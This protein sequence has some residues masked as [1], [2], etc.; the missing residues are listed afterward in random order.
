MKL[1]IKKLLFIFIF[2][3]V[4]IVL[5]SCGTRTYSL[6][7]PAEV[8]ANISNLETIEVGTEVKLT[9]NVPANKEVESFKVNNVEVS[10]DNLTYTFSIRQNTVVTVTFKDIVIEEVRYRLTLPDGVTANVS[11]LDSIL[12]NTEITLTVSVPEGKF[13][14]QLKINN[15]VVSVSNN[16]YTFNITRNTV[17]SV[18]FGDVDPEV[19]TY[20]LTLPANVTAN[21]AN[22]DRIVENTEVTLTVTPP[23]GKQILD[24]LLD[25]VSVYD[26][27]VG[28]Q[29]TFNIS[30]NTVVTVTFE[31]I[32]EEEKYSLTLPSEVIANVSNLEN[33]LKNTEITLTVSVPAG[34]FLDQLKVNNAVV[35]VSNNKYTFNITQNTVVTVIFGDIDPGETTY[36][37]TLP[38]GVTAN[39]ANLDRIVEN[40]EVTL[41]VTPPAG[42]EIDELFLD[43]VPV[44]VI[45]NQYTFNINQNIVVTVTFKDIPGEE[46]WTKIGT[47]ALAS[48]VESLEFNLLRQGTFNLEYSM[49]SPEVLTLQVKIDNNLNFSEGIVFL[50]IGN[51]EVEMFIQSPYIYIKTTSYE[52]GVVTETVKE[53]MYSDL[54]AQALEMFGF[55][56]V[57]SFLPE[58]DRILDGG[59]YRTNNRF[60]AN[61]KAMLLEMTTRDYIPFEIYQLDGKTKVIMTLTGP[62]DS[63]L[64]IPV[65]NDPLIVEIILNNGLLEKISYNLHVLNI[66][67]EY[68]N[69][70]I[71]L[72]SDLNT[73]PK[74]FDVS[75]I[76]LHFGSEVVTVEVDQDYISELEVVDSFDPLLIDFAFSIISPYIENKTIEGVY[77]DQAFTTKAKVENLLVDEVHLYYKVAE[78][79]Q[80]NT[81]IDDFFSGDYFSL[82]SFD[83][84]SG[85]FEGNEG[86]VYLYDEEFHYF[87]KQTGELY[88]IDMDEPITAV[89]LPGVYEVESLKEAFE[90]F[91]DDPY[92]FVNNNYY[93][94]DKGIVIMNEKGV[95]IKSDIYGLE[96][97]LYIKEPETLD[98]VDMYLAVI[99]A[100]TNAIVETVEDY[101][102]FADPYF[103]DIQTMEDDIEFL[104][105]FSSGAMETL[106]LKQMKQIGA[107]DYILPSS[108][109]GYT[110]TLIEDG[111]S[112]VYNEFGLFDSTLGK[113]VV[114]EGTKTFYYLF[115]LEELPEPVLDNPY[116]EVVGYKIGDDVI[117]SVEDL[118][119]YVTDSK[120]L[121]L[122][123][124][125]DLKSFST[126]LADVK[127]EG[128][129]R[130]S[131][132]AHPLYLDLDEFYFVFY[133]DGWLDETVIKLDGS[134]VEIYSEINYFKADLDGLAL[135]KLNSFTFNY[136]FNF[137]LFNHHFAY[138]QIIKDVFSG[139]LTYEMVE[140]EYHFENG[141]VVRFEYGQMYI[142]PTSESMSFGLTTT[143]FEFTDQLVT[144]YENSVIIQ[145]DVFDDIILKTYDE[146]FV[147][148]P[149][150]H[151]GVEGYLFDNYYLVTEGIK[152]DHVF[153][154]YDDYIYNGGHIVL[155]AEYIELLPPTTYLEKFLI[156][157]QYVLTS[158]SHE[159]KVYKDVVTLIYRHD[160]L[161]AY[162]DNF[163]EVAY[164]F[165]DDDIIRL[166][167]FY[168]IINIDKL[169]QSVDDEDF[170]L[171]SDDR[172]SLT[173][174]YPNIYWFEMYLD[175]SYTYIDGID[176]DEDVYFTFAIE[177]FT[178]PSI[179][180]SEAIDE[181][182]E[183]VE[184]AS[185]FTAI[186]LNHMDIEE[187]VWVRVYFDTGKQLNYGLSDFVDFFGATLEVDD[188]D[189]TL[190]YMANGEEVTHR[191][192]DHGIFVFDTSKDSVVILDLVNEAHYLHDMVSLPEG[193]VGFS[194]IINWHEYGMVVT[195]LELQQNYDTGSE[196]YLSAYTNYVDWTTAS[197][198][199]DLHKYIEVEYTSVYYGHSIT[200]LFDLEDDVAIVK[201]HGKA[202]LWIVEFNDESITITTDDYILTTTIA[203]R[204]DDIDAEDEKLPL[205]DF[206]NVIDSMID[207]KNILS[208]EYA[209][210]DEDGVYV[211]FE[212]S[213]S[214]TIS[215]IELYIFSGSTLYYSYLSLYQQKP[216]RP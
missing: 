168:S 210:L 77:L 5:A 34:K 18:V 105:L 13:L 61:L 39:V 124:E 127:D 76:H 151:I 172:Y 68:S 206:A 141:A 122:S 180:F 32:P 40:A 24:L 51:S 89:K 109:N 8:T 202:Q 212:N 23:A 198:I 209:V 176:I 85:Y 111:I 44:Y 156:N 131:Y 46:L 98:F 143:T 52:D 170:I 37:L 31:N 155:F 147:A 59:P 10:L 142:T 187:A 139:T 80:L 27:I 7:L 165:V 54:T 106:T 184:V 103:Q 196:I 58:G 211:D 194:E 86:I 35:S 149:Y 42:K 197:E 123:Y 195:L 174:S 49:G 204:Y 148:D 22:L 186:D 55:P 191:F 91:K 17:V 72:P 164:I 179:D 171:V 177:S 93:N 135:V 175:E 140:D 81:I 95:Q 137:T 64:G 183:V 153:D 100:T 120:I 119:N 166:M 199:V 130:I 62:N 74:T 28:S 133:E 201:V 112:R 200:Y 150:Y 192:Y 145:S 154:Y 157:E 207:I 104:V 15:D 29:Y 188:F 41:T 136:L 128:H 208:G 66:D 36:K 14:D 178:I 90:G 215:V 213:I 203:D 87:D 60:N 16:K 9:V 53:S 114:I 126:L 162:I 159:I 21:V 101:L 48:V 144:Q 11:G 70:F 69:D 99:D 92:V 79:K 158:S 163:S 182:I 132:F 169:V 113:I 2:L 173:K 214:L 115:T 189:T 129:L 121:E 88:I 216:A 73:Y 6:T 67:I 134:I 102:I 152:D 181:Q 161:F 33:I 12:E 94:K 138:M 83:V 1:K 125:Y 38:A 96:E 3:G 30:Q 118:Q 117:T 82:K 160:E 97:G 108:A 167:D 84:A 56:L 63:I 146:T 4:A 20:K 185:M 25:G 45:D 57:S 78:P 19:T 75:T 190:T 65:T 50:P 205:Y 43:G 47:A 107:L 26:D 193:T 110:F 116:Y 71:V